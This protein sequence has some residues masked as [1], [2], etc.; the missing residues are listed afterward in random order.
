M[1]NGYKEDKEKYP[2]VATYFQLGV[3]PNN[4]SG[5]QLT[6]DCIFCNAENKLYRMENC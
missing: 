6:C 1:Y 2:N 5:K 3:I 4:K